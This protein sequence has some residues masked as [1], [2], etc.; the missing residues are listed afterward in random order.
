ML[1]KF[2]GKA[3]VIRKVFHL[4]L[5][6]KYLSVQFYKF[7]KQNNIGPE[8]I[9]FTNES[10]FPLYAYMNKG[11]K[12]IRLTKKTRR[13]LKNG[14]EK[15]INFVTISIIIKKYIKFLLINFLSIRI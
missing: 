14:N 2:I 3:K 10:I 5:Y 7:M 4:S 8:N 1:N 13:N 9:F 11:T 12:K 15:S 6:D